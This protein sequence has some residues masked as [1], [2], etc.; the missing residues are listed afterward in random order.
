MVFVLT[1]FCI[2]GLPVTYELIRIV[3]Y[4]KEKISV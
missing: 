4:G 3:A 2:K 1:S